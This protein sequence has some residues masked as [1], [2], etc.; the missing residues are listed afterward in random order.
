MVKREL[1][2]VFMEETLMRD[3]KASRHDWRSE[4]ITAIFATIAQHF[5]EYSSDDK[6]YLLA[7]YEHEGTTLLYQRL[8]L[9]GKALDDALIT[10]KPF[11]LPKGF[12]RKKGT[13]LPRFLYN[14]F[15]KVLDDRGMPRSLWLTVYK[16]CPEDG[17]AAVSCIR[18]L[19]LLWSKVVV[20]ASSDDALKAFE[21]RMF[22]IP[23]ITADSD[24][25]GRARG[26]L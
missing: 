18:Q 15:T 5:P 8:P 1:K 2:H 13:R 23:D 22:R 17:F 24:L 11:V 10:G 12:P 16:H 19:T 14:L 7:R 25:L 4:A 26:Y 20:K 3:L 9:L 6:E 21:A